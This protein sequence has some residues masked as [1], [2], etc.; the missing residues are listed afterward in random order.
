MTKKST[1][2]IVQ[3]IRDHLDN[4]EATHTN[5]ANDTYTGELFREWHWLD[6]DTETNLEDVELWAHHM[7][8]FDKP[9]PRPPKPLNR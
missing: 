4:R 8:N 3:L 5:T 6:E 2:E 1:A 9:L 7:V